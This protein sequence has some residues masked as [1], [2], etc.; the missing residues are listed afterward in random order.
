MYLGGIILKKGISIGIIALFIVSAVSP[1][2][3][4]FDTDAITEIDEEAEPEST[5]TYGPMNSSWPMFG[6]D[7]HH[8]GQSQYSTADN[9]GDEKWRFKLEHWNYGGPAIDENGTIYFG[10]SD[11]YLYAFYP[12]GTMK[13]KYGASLV[14]SVPAIASDGTIY[15]GSF[16]SGL[17][18]LY[19]NGTKKWKYYL[20]DCRKISSPI[21]DEDGTIYFGSTANHR[22]YAVN[23]NGVGKWNFKAG[24]HVCSSPAISNDGTIYVGSDDGYLYALYPNGTLRWRYKL[25]GNYIIVRGDPSIAEDGTIYIG[26]LSPSGSDP[27][28]LY[29]LYPNGTMKWKFNFDFPYDDVWSSASIGEDGT[30]YIGASKLYAIYPNGTKKWSFNTGGFIVHSSPAIGDDGTIYIGTSKSYTQGGDIIAI[31]PDGTEKWRKLIANRYV[32]SSPAIGED[33]TV[34][35]VS[36]SN[37]QYEFSYGYLHAFGIGAFKVDANG[38]YKGVKNEPIQFTGEAWNGTE[39]YTWFWD[40]GDGQTSEE[41]NPLH[42]YEAPCEVSDYYVVTLTVTDSTGNTSGDITRVRIGPNYPPWIP[43]IDGPTSGEVGVI[44][45]YTFV[46]SD[47]DGDDVYYYIEWGDGTNTGWIGPY[48]SGEEITESHTWNTQGNYWIMAKAKDIYGEESDWAY[49]EVTMPKNKQSS[50]MWFLRW[51]E[52]FPLLNQI[53]NL[54]MEKWI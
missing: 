43:F 17:H 14:Y 44:Y 39:P 21:I 22:I 16:D 19:P 36:S 11:D 7:I 28:C 18:A 13:W 40:F 38:P 9:P 32:Q 15:V 2:V 8:T 10:S 34:Y 35:I 1:M 6:H 20:P 25:E 33:G 3:I 4:G 50:N 31:N 30:I 12:N 23:P 45:N 37:T 49:L 54:L 27:K 53:A 48:K 5:V 29:A 51:L 47:Y 24:S 26:P 42:K 41:Q 46:T 52:R